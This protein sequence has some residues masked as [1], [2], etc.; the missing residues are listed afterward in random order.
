MLQMAWPSD[1][2]TSSSVPRAA[3]RV[4]LSRSETI[5]M[6]QSAC[7]KL[8]EAKHGGKQTKPGPCVQL[9]GASLQQEKL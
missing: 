3:A 9:T 8:T 6:A 2:Y 7:N 5:C 1:M 4:A